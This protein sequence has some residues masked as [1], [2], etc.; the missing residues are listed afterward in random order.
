MELAFF[1]SD[2]GEN[3]VATDLAVSSWGTDH[4]H[5]VA[6]SGAMAR[7]L[8]QRIEAEGR[9]DLRPA[10][11]TADLFRPAG[12]AP[13]TFA[14]DV[15]RVGP[16]L[17]LIDVVAHQEGRAVAR[18]S[19]LFLKPTGSTE[20]E[21]W[22]P[23]GHPS[24]PPEDVAPPTTEPHVPF[25]HSDAG[26]SQDFREHQNASRKTSWNSAV[27]VVAGEPATAF[28]AAA[29]IAD[30]ASLVTNWGTRG[31]EH[32]NTDITLTLVRRPAGTEIGLQAVDRLEQDGI[33]VG[34]ASV[35]DREGPLGTIVLTSLANA[36]RTVDLGKEQWEDDGR[37]TTSG[38]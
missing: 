21:V 18:A 28:Q 6:V 33:A 38:A 23:G 24:P 2:D 13:M 30:G 3:L 32:I 12:R 15:V 8:E 25:L 7:A 20:G 29:A 9:T 27:P 26:W 36:R 34:T 4:L 11:Y 17:A 37:R 1:T 35:F 10:R 19:A 22:S 16:R 31:V 14:T 5:G